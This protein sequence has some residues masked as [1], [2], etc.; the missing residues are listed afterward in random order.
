M[1]STTTPATTTPRARAYN[2]AH[3]ALTNTS[4][5]TEAIVGPLINDAT[6]TTH[7]LR[8]LFG[9]IRKPFLVL[10]WKHKQMDMF[11]YRA[12]RMGFDYAK[13][14]D[15]DTTH[16]RRTARLAFNA[17]MDDQLEMDTGDA[18][19]VK[20]MILQH[21]NVFNEAEAEMALKEAIK[22]KLVQEAKEDVEG[23]SMEQE[24]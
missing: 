22:A 23:Q 17:T 15:E 16:P 24:A 4:Q 14:T 7:D 10:L 1:A 21:V 3:E 19:E 8:A 2:D 11:L 13:S 9:A 5:R 12:E 6:L 20:K 18:K